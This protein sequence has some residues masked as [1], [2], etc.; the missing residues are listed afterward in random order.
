MK[1]IVVK[2]GSRILTDTHGKLDRVAIAALAHDIGRVKREKGVEVVV[3]TSGAVSAGRAVVSL[4]D[5]RMQK[6]AVAYSEAILK[7]QVLASI[8]QPLVMHAWTE[9][10]A[11]CGMYCAQLLTTRADFATRKNYLS[12]RSVT[13]NLITLGIVPVFN[14]NDVLTPERLDFTD[15]DQQACM[16]AAMIAADALVILSDVDGVYDGSP[17]DPQS[18]L[19]PVITDPLEFLD[20]ID[21]TSG[22]GKG[23]MKSK[24]HAADLA[25]TLG[26]DMYIVHGKTPDVIVK[27]VEG[28]MG[29]HFPAR[30]QKGEVKPIKAWLASAAS[31]TG[32]IVVSTFLADILRKKRVAS[33]LYFG[34]EQVE[35]SFKEGDVVDV[36]DDK[37]TILA[38]GVV[39]HGAQELQEKINAYK[40]LAADARADL[41]TSKIIAVHYDQLVFV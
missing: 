12:I 16:I 39:R 1:R 9:G 41:K 18:K 28:G 7:E 26:I 32:K 34:I 31:G 11:A 8:G 27:T 13:L 29:T 10:F 19:V 5:F 30:T 35:G 25:T 36:C 14:E 15:N 20:R 3:V 17:K 21:A 6:E 22:S 37:G 40:A 4:D 33:V 38:R 23:G 2:I 24:L